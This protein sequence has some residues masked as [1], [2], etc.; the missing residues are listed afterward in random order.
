MA[1]RRIALV[2]GAN[3]GIGHEI[4]LQLLAKKWTVVAT[5]RS[6]DKLAASFRGES[7]NLH[8][9]ELDV[10]D[11]ESCGELA[12]SLHDTP[13][14]IDVLINNAGIMGSKALAEFDLDEI[15]RVMD[16]NFLGPVRVTKYLL[17]LLERGTSP[18]IINLSSQLSALGGG[19]QGYG[20]Y[21]LSKWALNGFTLLGSAEL[22]SRGI[23]VFSMCPGWVKTDM[24]GPSAP[25]SLSEG[26][27]TA[28][29]LAESQ[30]PDSGRFYADRRSRPY[31][32]H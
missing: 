4:A 11:D 13:G 15:Q 1:D 7:G 14:K 32:N 25:R 28:V 9:A 2:T 10:T 30:E 6:M 29:W 24:G 20:A 26:A 31:I 18:R 27:D 16:V 12:L 3:R 22:A 23:E 19:A 5:A 17:P 21:R 8:L